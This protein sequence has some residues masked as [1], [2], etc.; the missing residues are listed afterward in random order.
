[1]ENSIFEDF[2]DYLGRVRYS[3]KTVKESKNNFFSEQ[4]I[5]QM[6]YKINSKYCKIHD[7][8]IE[9]KATFDKNS[10]KIYDA[11]IED[12][13]NKLKKLNFDFNYNIDKIKEWMKRFNTSNSDF[14]N[15]YDR[16]SENNTLYV[17]LDTHL[18]FFDDGMSPDIKIYPFLSE[19]DYQDIQSIQSFFEN[20]IKDIY[21]KKLLTFLKAQKFDRNRNKRTFIKYFDGKYTL[22]KIEKLESIFNQNQ[23]PKEFAIMVCLLTQYGYVTINSRGRKAFYKSWY[24]FINLEYPKNENFYSI[25]K[26]IEDTSISGFIFK[27]LNDV[28]YLHLE[29]MFENEF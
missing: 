22:E 20:Y 10:K 18:G 23:S 26:F 15:W 21:V 3:E 29:K 5:I 16:I 14:E 11:K 2:I 19:L 1:M 27:E 9:Y 8:L 7:E 24:D 25:N 4:S 17:I 28:T 12:Y 6:F 13:I